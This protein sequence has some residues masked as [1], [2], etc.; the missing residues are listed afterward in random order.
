MQDVMTYVLIHGLIAAFFTSLGSMAVLI[1]RVISERWVKSS[2]GFAAGVM[3]VTSF[4]SLILPAMDYGY[5]VETGI[6]ILLGL[7]LIVFMDKVIPHQHDIVGYEG[8]S[9]FKGKWRK[10]WLLI[11]AMIIH[12]I[13]EGL[14]IGVTTVYD[15]LLGFSTTIAIGIQDIPEGATVSIPLMSIGYKRSK[16]IAI[17]IISGLVELC[18]ALISALL[19]YQGGLILGLGMGLAGGA[20]IYVVVEELLPE[21]FHEKSGDRLYSTIGFFVGFYLMLYLELLLGK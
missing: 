12:N 3:L 16:A 13:P 17:G 8:L 1:K 14:A 11:I 10:T 9:V 15:K 20:M 19:F 7:L 5:Y 21:I 18:A 6:G 4:T 2:L